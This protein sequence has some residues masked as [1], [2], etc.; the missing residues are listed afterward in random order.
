MKR[1]L[2]AST[3][4]LSFAACSN[5]GT[6]DPGSGSDPGTG[7]NT[8]TVNGTVSAQAQLTN[9]RNAGEFTTNFSVRIQL[10]G[11]DV[12]DGNVTMTSSTGT[13]VLTYMQQNNGRWRGT[14]A[15]Y[16]EVYVLDID[17]GT[18]NVHDVRVDGPVIH[19]F[20]DPLAGATVDATMPLLIK[21]AGGHGADSAA[22]SADNI[23]ALSIPDSGSY[24][25]AGGTLRSSKDQSRQNDLRLTRTNRV[26][27]AGAAGGS[28][29]AVSIE[30]DISVVAQPNPLAP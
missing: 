21:W 4:L 18:D 7:T 14:A 9:A 15:G 13:V 16:D 6:L 8:L 3:L 5:T 22:L 2:F 29:L 19:T 28:E 27:P 11:Q 20:T 24:S 25:L 17:R 10:A 1:S 12:T 26:T 23:D 30:N